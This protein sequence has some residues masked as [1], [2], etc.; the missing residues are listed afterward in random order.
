MYGGDLEI[1]KK[2]WYFK[3]DLLKRLE[4]DKHIPDRFDRDWLLQ[5]HLLH[6]HENIKITF[7]KED[8]LEYE[9]FFKSRPELLDI[10]Y[11][12]YFETLK[13]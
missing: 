13:R 12:E 11:Y 2:L 4:E 8:L 7:T 9:P 3:L 6:D 5:D 10:F 1:C